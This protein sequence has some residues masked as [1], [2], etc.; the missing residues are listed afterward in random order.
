MDL[1]QLPGLLGLLAQ[2][3]RLFLIVV[4]ALLLSLTVH[5]FAHAYLAYR[6]GDRSVEQRGYLTLNPFRYTHPVLSILLPLLALVGGGFA[7]P[8]GAV[9]L[10]RHLFRSRA[11][12]AAASAAGPAVNLVLGLVCVWAAAAHG[13][14]RAPDGA[15]LARQGPGDDRQHPGEGLAEAGAVVVAG[16]GVRAHGVLLKVGVPL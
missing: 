7:L 9:Y 6:A 5:E 8:G 14:A 1:S 15:G 12:M 16:G 3:L 2:D 11:A 4:P 10:H 13:T